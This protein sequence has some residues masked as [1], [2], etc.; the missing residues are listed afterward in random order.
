MGY[1]TPG[2]FS[3]DYDLNFLLQESSISS[4]YGCLPL[5]G[6]PFASFLVLGGVR[7]LKSSLWTLFN[8]C[9]LFSPFPGL[10]LWSQPALSI[11]PSFLQRN[12]W[13]WR[14]SIQPSSLCSRWDSCQCQ[15]GEG[16][17]GPTVL[18]QGFRGSFQ[19]LIQ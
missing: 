16:P 10:C 19:N 1:P 13:C 17:P 9:F 7:G 6:S 11:Q 8:H 5:V 18:H 14:W 12:L 2:S 15:A 3:V 4:N